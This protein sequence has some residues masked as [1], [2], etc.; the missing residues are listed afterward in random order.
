MF[1]Q[2]IFLCY[3]GKKN[4]LHFQVYLVAISC[5]AT[6]DLYLLVGFLFVVSL[7]KPIGN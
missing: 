6:Y 1:L 3:H 7:A 5:T 2:D 4:Q